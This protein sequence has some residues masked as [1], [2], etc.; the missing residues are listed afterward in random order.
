VL[1]AIPM[2]VAEELD[3]DWNSVRVEQAPVDKAY[4]NPMFGMQATGGSTTVRAHWEP[5]RKA[6]AAA[7]EM[8]VT[9]AAAQWQVPTSEC[10]TE[11]GQVIHTSG[12]KLG[13][14]ALVDAAAKLPVPAEPVLK[15]PKDFRLLGKPTRRLDSP[16]KVNGTAKFGIDAQLP[17][18]LVAVMARAPQPGARPV[19]VDDAKT[20]AVKGV[21]QVIT[22]PSGVA[23]LADGYWAAKKGR[24]AL[25]IEWDLGPAAGLSS[26]KI[27]AALARPT[28]WRSPPAGRTKRRPR[29]RPPTR[30]PTSPMPAWSR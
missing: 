24:D 12:R 20:K 9:A 27:S 2:L 29:S 16:G 21:R 13:Y 15:D 28:R 1:T 4:D 11:A 17:G 23:V 25:A 19:K 8:L 10:R 30:R 7:R 6:G 3:A 22:I 26:D 14:G 18:L 5:L